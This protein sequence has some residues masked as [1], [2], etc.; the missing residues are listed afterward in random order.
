MSFFR[1]VLA[2]SILYSICHS[3]PAT[4]PPA[5]LPLWSDSFR[6]YYL[7]DVE[8]G[9]PSQTI[10]VDFDT[11]SSLTWVVG[12]NLSAVGYNPST[13]S[14]YQPDGRSWSQQY[15][16]GIAKGTYVSDVFAV[17]ASSERD[18]RGVLHT[19]ANA[20]GIQARMTFGVA[21]STQQLNVNGL[22]GL[23]F[24]QLSPSVP[25]PLFFDALA[26]ANGFAERVFGIWFSPDAAAMTPEAVTR[27]LH[28]CG[29][30]MEEVMNHREMAA[31]A[32]SSLTVSGEMALGGVDTARYTGPLVSFR[33]TRP[34]W[35]GLFVTRVCLGPPSTSL[36]GLAT[37]APAA[38]AVHGANATPGLAGLTCLPGT[39]ISTALPVS[40]A[41]TVR[42]THGVAAAV[43]LALQR[44][45]GRGR[46]HGME[47]GP[48]RNLENTSSPSLRNPPADCITALVPHLASFQTAL[49]TL[50]TCEG[51]TAGEWSCNGGTTCATVP[52]CFPAFLRRLEELAPVC[53]SWATDSCVQAVSACPGDGTALCRGGVEMI[54]DTGTSLLALP[55]PVLEGVARGLGCTM[56]HNGGCVFP[57]A[58]PSSLPTIVLT[59]ATG[60]SMPSTTMDL[61]LPAR[62][63]SS[64]SFGA[65]CAAMISAPPGGVAVGGILGD[66]FLRAFYTVYDV[67]TPAVRL[68][69]AV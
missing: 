2:L 52:S 42:R 21:S 54:A 22:V 27:C 26:R 11:G 67:A 5:L 69:V 39:E 28:G 8:W 46:T 44:G 9:T 50:C 30:R 7:G 60:G 45:L 38:G 14:S 24:P 65:A 64:T 62:L 1:F 19:D 59:L 23:A 48:A 32:V 16:I 40:S 17:G 61:G 13:S 18:G 43:A 6:L 34:A 36:R 4:A 3:T 33:L 58:C 12:R 63:Y 51:A 53:V 31:A 37:W 68:G 47:G 15:G 55:T 41:A 35:W 57:G 10:R 20:S 66:T 49:Q 29:R 25:Q 56:S